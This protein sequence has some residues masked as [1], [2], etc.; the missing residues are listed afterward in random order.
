[1]FEQCAPARLVLLGALADAENLSIT[2]TIYPD[3]HQQRHIAN[4]AG[5]TAL[6]HN[7]VE[8]DIRMFA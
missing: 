7:A 1:M 5:P 2:F 3:R 8:I 4:L 6:E